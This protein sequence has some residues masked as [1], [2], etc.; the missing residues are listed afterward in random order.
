MHSRPRSRLLLS[1]S[2]LV[3]SAWC[4]CCV[5]LCRIRF[6]FVRLQRI[7]FCSQVQVDDQCCPVCASCL[8]DGRPYREGQTWTTDNP[9]M[10]CQCRHGIV[11]CRPVKCVAACASGVNV[12]GK[13]CPVCRGCMYKNEVGEKGIARK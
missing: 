3:Q 12:P 4:R 11:T 2:A 1:A 6:Y 5:L 9:C 13:C 7:R 10:E 8:V